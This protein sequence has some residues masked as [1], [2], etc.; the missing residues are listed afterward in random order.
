ML[1]LSTNKVSII[2]YFNFLGTLVDYEE[3]KLEHNY[4]Y[5]YSYSQATGIGGGCKVKML[6]PEYVSVRVMEGAV[7]ELTGEAATSKSLFV[8]NKSVVIYPTEAKIVF[9]GT[10]VNAATALAKAAAPDLKLDGEFQF[11]A[12]VAPEVGKLKAPNSPV[13]GNANVFIFPNINAGNIGYKIAQRFGGYMALGPICQG[14]AKPINDLSRGCNSDDV[15]AV[16]AI[17]ALQA[18]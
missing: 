18:Q 16:V 12:A 6:L 14:F 11:D 2:A 15:I 4:G 1:Y 9:D 7:D 17:T 5:V 3:E 10:K 8:R 13:A